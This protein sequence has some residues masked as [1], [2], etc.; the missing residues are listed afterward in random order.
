MMFTVKTV[1]ETVKQ[2]KRREENT[3]DT[4]SRNI[5]WFQMNSFMLV[6]KQTIFTVKNK[7]QSSHLRKAVNFNIYI[8]LASFFFHVNWDSSRLKYSRW[9]SPTQVILT[10]DGN[11]IEINWTRTH[12]SKERLM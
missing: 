3:I 11:L 12:A 4:N 10:V 8:H 6:T 5:I 9:P 2:K 1:R 7:S